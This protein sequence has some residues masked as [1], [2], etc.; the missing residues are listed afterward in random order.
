MKK[1]EEQ[2]QEL[3]VILANRN[4]TIAAAESCTGGAFMSALVSVPGVSEVLAGGVVAY[5]EDTKVKQL[6]VASD[7]IQRY[8]IVSKQVAGEMAAGVRNMFGTDIGVG[9]TGFAGPSG[10]RV[11]EVCFG[12]DF[13]GEVTTFDK[14]FERLARKMVIHQSVVCLADKLFVE[15]SK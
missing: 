10:E 9:V 15:L 13:C 8:G 1:F 12:V 5:S 14:R 6:G 2:M 7:T 4:L 3:V 11:G